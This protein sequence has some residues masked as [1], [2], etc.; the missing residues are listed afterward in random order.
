MNALAILKTI[1]TLLPVIIDA[2][3][4]IEAAIPQ[5]GKGKEKLAAVRSIIEIGYG[6]ANAIW[7]AVEKT[8]GV[9][10]GLF[11]ATG[12]FSTATK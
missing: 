4:A 12:V 10:V 11:N 8:V 9:L 7:P 5:Y 2:V 1:L 6:E 3:K